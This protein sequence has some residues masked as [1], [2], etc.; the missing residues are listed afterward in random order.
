MI[1]EDIM[2]QE[3]QVVYFSDLF[4][5][6]LRRWKAIMVLAL[7]FALALGGLQ[8]LKATNKADTDTAD[9][10]AASIAYNEQQLKIIS[11]NILNQQKYMTESALMTMDPYNSGKVTV[12]VYVYT[13]YQIMPGMEYQNTDKTMAVMRSYITELQ[14]REALDAFCAATS[15]DASYVTELIT[16]ETVAN[17]NLLSITV[18][19]PDMGNAQKLAEAVVQQLEHAQEEVA[20]RITEH[21]ISIVSTPSTE[22]VDLEAA[23]AQSDA[24]VRLTNLQLSL[25]TAKTE[26]KTLRNYASDTKTANP[27]IM[28]A[29]GA[30]AGVFLA[31]A[32]AVVT[33]LCSDKIYSGRV[34]ENRVDIRVLGALPE[35]SASVLNKLEGRAT[36]P[37]YDVLAMNIRNYC[38]AHTHL[39]LLGSIPESHREAL[40][41]QLQAVGI[42]AAFDGSPMTTASALKQLQTHQAVVLIYTCG[43]SLYT[44]AQ[45]EISMLSDQGKALLGCV[46]LDG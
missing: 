35:K 19:C 1:Q 13:D 10:A 24:A 46:L 29:L 7:V 9:S 2:E 6:V 28:A 20:S 22:P 26:L 34:L 14:S 8:Y 16:T 42:S 21:E 31:A 36:K 5:A 44:Q 32:W 40:C 38:G 30:F 3:K 4:F 15:I 18:R 11:E 33:H 12:D 25:E 39:L 37:L 43:R 23:K 27:L 41:E 17:S 45:K